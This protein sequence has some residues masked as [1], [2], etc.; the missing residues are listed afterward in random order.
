MSVRAYDLVRTM[1]EEHGGTM[2]FQRKGFPPGGAW[3]ISYQG[4]EKAFPTGGHKFPGID[5]LHVPNI[6][7][8]ETWEDYKKE[9]IPGGWDLLLNRLTGKSFS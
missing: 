4:W 1:V 8:P 2:W 3:V 7:F 5:D 9:L 6:P